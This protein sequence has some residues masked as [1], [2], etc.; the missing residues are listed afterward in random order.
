MVIRSHEVTLYGGNDA[1]DIAKSCEDSENAFIARLYEAEGTF[2]NARIDLLDGA[3]YRL[4]T[5]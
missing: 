4:A 2:T 5:E 3:C 1:Y